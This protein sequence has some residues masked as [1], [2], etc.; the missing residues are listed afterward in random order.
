MK[1]LICCQLS[2]KHIEALVEA[3]T[4]NESTRYHHSQ[5]IFLIVCLPRHALTVH[6][7]LQH[8]A[9]QYLV[10]YCVPVSEVAGRQ[11]FA[12][13]HPTSASTGSAMSPQYICLGVSLLLARRSGTHCPMNSERILERQSQL[14]VLGRETSG[15][16]LAAAVEEMEM[17]RK[18]TNG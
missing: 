12:F 1:F 5:H 3:C 7:C 16:V 11:H 17:S 8:K 6:R 10:N 13:C 15:S 9:P 14:E 4:A 18:L 2:S